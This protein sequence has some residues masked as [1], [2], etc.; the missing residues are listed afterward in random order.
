MN[1]KCVKAG[2]V[3]YFLLCNRSLS[4]QS[5]LSFL[6]YTVRDCQH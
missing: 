6:E 4:M 2:K 5:I 3:S 1:A